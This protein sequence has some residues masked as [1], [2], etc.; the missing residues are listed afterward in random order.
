METQ[1][2][3]LG[4]SKMERYQRCKVE[5]RMTQLRWLEGLSRSPVEMTLFGAE[6]A[7][8]RHNRTLVDGPGRR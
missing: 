3:C 4:L 2:Q 8:W 5:S 1:G 7:A 6:A